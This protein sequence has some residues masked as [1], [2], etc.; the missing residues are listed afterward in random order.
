MERRK[1]KSYTMNLCEGS[2]L[3]KLLLFALPL[4]ASSMLQLFFNA[5]DIVVVG[6]FAGDNSLAA[7]GSNGSIINLLTNVFMGLSVGTNVLVARFFAAKEEDIL[8]RTVHTSVT[9]SVICGILL[10]GIGAI[11]ARPILELMQSPAEV[12]DLA[13]LYLRIYFLGMPATMAYNFGAA[14]LRG[15]GDT[16]RPLYYLFFSGIINVG[17]NCLFVIVFHMD[18]AGVAL[19]TIISQYISA[20]LVLRCLTREEE[21]IRLERQYLGIDKRILIQILRIGLPAGIQ[22]SLFSLSNAVIQSSINGFGA[23]IVAGNSAAANIEGFVYVAMNAFSQATVAFV[24]QNVGAGKY[25]RINKVV[26]RAILSV[27]VIGVILGNGVFLFGESLLGLYSDSSSV[28]TAGLVRFSIVC[29][30]YALC[31]V[32]DSMVGALRGLGCS[33]LPT[34]VSLMGAC[35]F[36]IV[37]I[38]IL[39][40]IE[41]F[42]TIKTLYWAYPIS[43]ALTA[44][45][46][47]IS[48]IIVRRKLKQRWGV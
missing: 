14:I 30:T 9:V 32:M 41:E 36:R 31:G 23:V 28:I 37:W 22:G 10:A 40:R 3:N 20:F 15:V 24:S 4:I 38:A 11:A 7:V 39:F 1:Q 27:L 18:V 5:A 25:E 44:S 16:K 35:V 33:I 17:L 46:H 2:I 21:G 45:V 19:A 13:T 8:R 26:I 48:F 34:I 12:I 6:K 43:W 47:I 29:T 42:H